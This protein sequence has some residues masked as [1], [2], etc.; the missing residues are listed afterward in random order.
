[1]SFAKADCQAWISGSKGAWGCISLTP[2]TV[3]KSKGKLPREFFLSYPLLDRFE[4]W[5]NRVLGKGNVKDS[6]GLG[7]KIARSGI[8]EFPVNNF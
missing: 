5:T 6:F 8:C 7:K 2:P 1:M 4:L 3:S